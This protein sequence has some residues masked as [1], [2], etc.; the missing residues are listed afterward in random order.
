MR[1]HK[2]LGIVGSAL[3]AV[4]CTQSDVGISASVKSKLAADD[5]VKARRIDVDTRDKVVTL[6]GEV[7]SSAEETQA[8]QLARNTEGVVDVVDRLS[9][10]PARGSLEVPTGTSGTE[11][12]R[13]VGDVM[14]DA[15]ITAAVKTKLMADPDTSAMRIDV[16][17]KDRV[18]T[19]TGR[20]DSAAQK[21]EAIE[22]AKSV[23]G[24]RS[25]TDRLTTGR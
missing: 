5:L 11:M 16:D 24:V 20:L 15:G 17:T 6:S 21:A 4:A 19:L 7:M 12:M 8:L 14:S 10:A 9:V 1:S 18:V 3:L 13:D 2:L 22:L 23:G 25:V